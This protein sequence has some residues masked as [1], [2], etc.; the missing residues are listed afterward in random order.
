MAWL[1]GESVW[2]LEEFVG[3]YSPERKKQ[4]LAAASSFQTHLGMFAGIC[5]F[6]LQ[7]GERQREAGAVFKISQPNSSS[8]REV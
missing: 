5:L 3:V 1:D 2:S 4:G 6:T 7:T 8:G